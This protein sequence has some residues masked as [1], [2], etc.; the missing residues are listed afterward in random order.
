M[1]LGEQGDLTCRKDNLLSA[2]VSILAYRAIS[3]VQFSA[4]RA[5]NA[6]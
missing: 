4:R 3:E 1:R 2:V 5:L 6:I